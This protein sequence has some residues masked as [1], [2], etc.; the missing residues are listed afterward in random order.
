MEEWKVR[1]IGQAAYGYP[2]VVWQRT[3]RT[4]DRS[5]RAQRSHKKPC[6]NGLWLLHGFLD[7]GAKLP[8]RLTIPAFLG[9]QI[10]FLPVIRA[11]PTECQTSEAMSRMANDRPARESNKP[12]YLGEPYS[13]DVAELHQARKARTTSDNRQKLRFRTVHKSDSAHF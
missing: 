2:E 13:A 7:Q 10:H 4:M 12:A 11:Y 5:N 8:T 1:F 6:Q 3:V 9:P